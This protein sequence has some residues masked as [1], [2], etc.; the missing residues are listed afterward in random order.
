MRIKKI[1]RWIHVISFASVLALCLFFQEPAAAQARRR[2][3]EKPRAGR[4]AA[5]AADKA[6]DAD[7][8]RHN[9]RIRT[10]PAS[11]ARTTK[12]RRGG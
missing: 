9:R 4:P 2:R 5:G 10:R 11:G 6:A 8:S 12:G 1:L 7:S 3:L